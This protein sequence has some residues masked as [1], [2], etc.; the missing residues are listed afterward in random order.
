MIKRSIALPFVLAVL[1]LALALVSAEPSPVASLDDP[2]QALLLPY[3]Q[4]EIIEPGSPG[5]TAK[6]TTFFA[7]GNASHQ[8][9][10]VTVEVWS[11]W[12]ILIPELT[13]ILELD[14][15]ALTTVNLQDW[16]VLG[17]L[18]DRVLDA[19]T[20]A[21]VQAALTGA[22]SPQ[23]DMFYSTEAAINLADGY[24][25]IRSGP[26]IGGW[27]VLWGDYQLVDAQGNLAGGAPL[28]AM[29]PEGQLCRGHLARYAFGGLTELQ[30]LIWTDLQGAPSAGPD[31][32]FPLQSSSWEIYDMDGAL[33][34]RLEL[35]LLAAQAIPTSALGL[36]E[37]FGWMDV[38]TTGDSSISTLQTADGMHMLWHTPC[39]RLPANLWLPAVSG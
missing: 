9:V 24:L 10:K 16:L 20:L 25:I 14:A 1:T 29:G 31:P 32:T 36:A 37:P 5:W 17:N 23:D 30:H 19:V 8:P 18:P 39:Q 22:R 4:V 3:F 28:V 33:R 15:R 6:P 26:T 34:R 11:N 27:D 7:V 21:H 35:D 2:S 13:T 12:G 38:Q